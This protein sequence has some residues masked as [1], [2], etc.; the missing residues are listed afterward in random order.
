MHIRHRIQGLNPGLSRGRRVYYRYGDLDPV[1]RFRFYIRGGH[2]RNPGSRSQM[3][4]VPL[5]GSSIP[6]LDVYL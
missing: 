4:F 5:V 1:V 3:C 6:K 2:I